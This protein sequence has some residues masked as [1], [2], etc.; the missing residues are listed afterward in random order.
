MAIDLDDIIDVLSEQQWALT[1]AWIEPDLARELYEEA[2][3]L[4]VSGAVRSASIGQG[5][6]QLNDHTVRK[7]QIHWFEPDN[8]TSVQAKFCE[9]MKQLQERLNQTCYLSL[10]DMECHYT[11]YPPGAFYGRHLDQFRHDKRRT[12][13]FLYYLNED[14]SAEEGG[15]L[16]LYLNDSEESYVDVLPEAGT[17]V[18]FQS[19]ALEHEVLPTER[20]RY[21]VVGWMKTR[22]TG[23][24]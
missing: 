24:R 15:A 11:L 6:Q 10:V 3:Q 23:L 14:W 18:M 5:A 2:H 12:I 19:G 9:R 22:G 16:R 8:L 7:T 21:G 4:Y 17:F 1:K 20:I 13:S